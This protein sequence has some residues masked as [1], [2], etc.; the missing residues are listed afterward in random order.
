MRSAMRL[1]PMRS[2]E[3]E[4]FG[5][6]PLVLEGLEPA[7]RNPRD[8]LR[9]I[10]LALVFPGG[11]RLDVVERRD[12]WTDASPVLLR[13]PEY[14]RATR[15]E[16]PLV[17][18]GRCEIDAQVRELLFLVAEAVHRIQDDENLL[19]L[20]AARIDVRHGLRQGAHR[21][22]D[23]AARVHPGDADDARVRADRALQAVD[24]LVGGRRCR[25]VVQRNAPRACA[26]LFDR[27]TDR[28]VM[29]VM[30]VRRAENLIA[31]LER[32]ALVDERETLGRAVRQ[33]DFLGLAAD[34]CRGRLLHPDRIGI[35]LCLVPQ[36]SI[37]AH[38]V[39][40]CR[41]RLRVEH[42]AK[43]FDRLAHRLRVRHDVELREV[44]PVRRQVELGANRSPVGAAIHGWGGG[45]RTG[46]GR[47][48]CRAADQGQAD[49]CH[50]VPAIQ[51]HEAHSWGNN[52][53]WVR[54]LLSPTDRTTV[55]MMC[56][57]TFFRDD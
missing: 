32:Q 18:A 34:V 9:R 46:E 40:N 48:R 5:H 52:Q 8:A 55:T 26:G 30:V 36:K 49:G 45:R 7:G 20:A 4:R 31:R 23:A 11:E 35:L 6:G 17:R 43:A 13:H 10:R 3:L 54:I 38:A 19:V 14:S 22:L 16:D 57:N 47:A 29:H 51:A 41:K 25:I 24:H 50:E 2:M 39:L 28:L 56:R 44:H 53:R 21:N 42:A 33:R 37:E 12:R 15:R 27:E 1:R